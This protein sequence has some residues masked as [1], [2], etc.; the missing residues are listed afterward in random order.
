MSRRNTVLEEYE[1]KGYVH[2]PTLCDRLGFTLAEGEQLASSLCCVILPGWYVSQRVVQALEQRA[3]ERGVA[4]LQR[5][6]VD[7]PSSIVEE[8]RDQIL[9]QWR[10]A[11][12]VNVK[13]V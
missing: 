9:E 13:K 3:V 2:L 12:N 8:L 4:A 7:V 6:R 1:A 11:F 5:T 10:E